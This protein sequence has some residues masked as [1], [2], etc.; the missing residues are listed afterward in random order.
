M[1]KLLSHVPADDALP[2]QP[3]MAE[4]IRNNTF[5]AKQVFVPSG[6]ACQVL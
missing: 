2:F 3:A 5:K 1:S 4:R 6:T